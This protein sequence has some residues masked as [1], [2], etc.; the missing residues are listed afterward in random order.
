MANS[1]SAKKRV[2]Q[3]AKDRARNRWRKGTYRDAIKKYEETI[4]HGSVEQ[5]QTELTGLYKLLDKTAAKGALKKN[6]ASRYKS[7]LTTKLN[8]KKTAPS[9]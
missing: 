9:A 8:H 6:T 5:A 1:E 4:L 7:R 2:R 3:N